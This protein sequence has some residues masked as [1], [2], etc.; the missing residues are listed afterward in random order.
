MTR[1]TVGHVEVV[2]GE[3]QHV[4]LAFADRS[5]SGW[6]RSSPPGGVT[7]TQGVEEVDARPDPRR[8]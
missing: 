2:T 4:E 7:A 5:P 1:V 6:N 8:R 3:P